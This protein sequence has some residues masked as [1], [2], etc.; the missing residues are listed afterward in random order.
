[1]EEMSSPFHLHLLLQG[2]FPHPIWGRKAKMGGLGRWQTFLRATQLYL[3]STLRFQFVAT[4]VPKYLLCTLEQT[5]DSCCRGEH[6]FCLGQVRTA[7][8]TRT[9]REIGELRT[10]NKEP[11]PD[12]RR[13][14]CRLAE[15]LPHAEQQAGRLNSGRRGENWS[16]ARSCSAHW[17]VSSFPASTRPGWFLEM[18][19]S[20]FSPDG[21]EANQGSAHIPHPLSHF[22]SRKSSMGS[23]PLFSVQLQH[24]QSLL[25]HGQFKHWVKK[26]TWWQQNPKWHKAAF[27]YTLTKGN[28]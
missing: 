26:G 2:V 22:I 12:T 7:E 16:S 18:K 27:W 21:E 9:T 24:N 3:S 19:P 23:K 10:S 6:H 28:H 4:P 20:C 8:V 15:V 11:P 25:G 13:S 1:M 14:H 17:G 5:D